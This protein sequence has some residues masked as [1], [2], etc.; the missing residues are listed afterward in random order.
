MTIPVTTSTVTIFRAAGL[1]ARD[2]LDPEPTYSAVARGV[3]AVISAASGSERTERAS[4]ETVTAHLTM[5]PHPAGLSHLD[6]VV[7][8]LGRAWEVEWVQD[9]LGLGLDH[10]SAGLVRFHGE[11][12]A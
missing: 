6:I 8:D 4:A 11:A 5:D 7:D 3:R 9:V 1:D 12:P 2:G 10:V